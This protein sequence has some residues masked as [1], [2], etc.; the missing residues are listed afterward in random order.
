MGQETVEKLEKEIA[1]VKEKHDTVTTTMG[2]KI[3]ELKKSVQ[4]HTVRYVGRVEVSSPSQL[5]IL[6]FKRV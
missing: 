2:A 4:Q 5:A 1:D 3:D 6:K